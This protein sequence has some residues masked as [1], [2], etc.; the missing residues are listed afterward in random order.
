MKDSLRRQ[1]AEEQGYLCAYCLQRISAD[2]LNTKIEHAIAQTLQPLKQLDYD[3]LLLCCKG[4]EGQSENHQHCDTKKKDMEIKYNPAT[5]PNIE[6]TIKYK[7]DGTIRSDDQE[8]NQQLND[9]L[10]LNEPRLRVNRK[11]ADNAL[12]NE[13]ERIQ[14]TWTKARIDHMI[15]DLRTKNTEG[16][17]KPFCGILLRR[18]TRHPSYRDI[19]HNN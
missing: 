7:R 15:E 4:N 13:L 3:N 16:K 12:I 8:W 10:N 2:P 17:L 5:Y 11:A 1:L 18:L 14:G 19:G 6:D 9:V